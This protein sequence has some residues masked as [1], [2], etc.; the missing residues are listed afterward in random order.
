MDGYRGPTIVVSPPRDGGASTAADT[1][2]DATATQVLPRRVLLWAMLVLGALT[3]GYHLFVYPLYITDEGIYM[4]QAWSVIREGRL[5]PYTYFYDHAPAGWLLISGWVSV[6]PFQFQTFGNAINTGRVLMLILHIISIFLLFHVTYRFSGHLSAA[7]IACFFFN[8]SPLAVYYQRQV[9]LDN[10][11]VFWILL[12]LYL[13]TRDDGRL[14]TVMLSGI[15]F[16]IGV[17]T[18]ENAIFFAP[19]FAYLLYIQVR[20]QQN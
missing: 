4:E 15:A 11:M 7:L 14:V 8:F 1:R 3:H 10:I 6:L 19:V 2:V 5:E 18:K 17:L 13:V 16:G 9:L 12:S 20:Q